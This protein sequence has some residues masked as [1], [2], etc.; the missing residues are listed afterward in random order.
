MTELDK[1]LRRLKRSNTHLTRK[2]ARRAFEVAAKLVLLEHPPLSKN[3]EVIVP[4]KKRGARCPI[5]L[6]PMRNW[7]VLY[8]HL[9]VKHIPATADTGYCLGCH[10]YFAGRHGVLQH[11]IGLDRFGKLAQHL[12]PA[13][14]AAAL[15]VPFTPTKNS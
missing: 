4:F 9:R 1:A 3:G 2:R 6:T 13:A 11:L 15:G 8:K 12:A 14:T 5:C 7:T 10:K